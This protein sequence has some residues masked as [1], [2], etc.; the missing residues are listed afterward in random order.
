MAFRYIPDSDFLAIDGAASSRSASGFDPAD[1]E[2][3]PVSELWQ[4][5]ERN[6][7]PLSFSLTDTAADP[8]VIAVVNTLAERDQSLNLAATSPVRD[9]DVD[10]GWPWNRIQVVGP[11]DMPAGSNAGADWELTFGWK[12]GVTARRV[13][14][15]IGHIIAALAWREIEPLEDASVGSQLPQLKS[16][17]ET[18][19]PIVGIAAGRRRTVPLT[20][21]GDF[22]GDEAMHDVMAFLDYMEDRRNT[23]LIQPSSKNPV[24]FF[25]RLD[26]WSYSGRRLQNVTGHFITDGLGQQVLT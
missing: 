26:K 11:D 3:L 8:R 21:K 25:G 15:R 22:F 10:D 16:N 13:A 19:I 7:A 12:S 1:V 17:S 9:I 6:S 2:S 4:S 14:W 24:F 5:T 23:A 20:W 18:T